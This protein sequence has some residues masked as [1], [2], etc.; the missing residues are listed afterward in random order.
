MALCDWYNVDGLRWLE[1]DGNALTFA[2]LGLVSDFLVA[3]LE[4]VLFRGAC[5][6]ASSRISA[7]TPRSRACRRSTFIEAMALS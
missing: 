5:S 3:V 7:R 2:A 4:E 6:S 1:S